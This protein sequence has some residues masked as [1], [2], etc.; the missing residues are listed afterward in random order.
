[1]LTRELIGQVH[2]IEIKTRR[3]V[4]EVFSGQYGSV[5]RGLGGR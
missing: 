2:R 1:M 4:N 3:L 5:F